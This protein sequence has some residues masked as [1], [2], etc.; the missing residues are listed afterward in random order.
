MT[1]VNPAGFHTEGQ[2]KTTWAPRHPAY[3]NPDLPATRMR[4]NWGTYSPAGDVKK[5]I[6]VLYKL[7]SEPEPP[8]HLLLG[9]TANTYAK[10]QIAQL[11]AD[12]E[13]YASWSESLKKDGL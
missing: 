7:A 10:Q 9:E 6:E 1:L 5:A 8:L 3:T 13:K 4:D 2:G 12:M 11:T